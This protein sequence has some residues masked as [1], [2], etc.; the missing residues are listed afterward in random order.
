MLPVRCFTCNKVL[1]NLER[2]FQMWKREVQYDP[3]DSDASLLPFFEAHRISR[4]CCRRIL[5]TCHDNTVAS[6]AQSSSLPS[7]I[8]VQ[9]K[10]AFPSLYLAR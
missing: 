4:Y 1:G 8:T 2:S 6:P 7:T 5:L 3:Q 10:A 9:E